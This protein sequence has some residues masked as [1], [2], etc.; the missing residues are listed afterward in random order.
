MATLLTSPIQPGTQPMNKS[1][2]EGYAVE[3]TV[4]LEIMSMGVAL[5]TAS[6]GVTNALLPLMNAGQLASSTAR[7]VSAGLTKLS[8]RPPKSCLT[9]RMATAL[10]MTIIHQGAVEGRFSPSSTPVT[11]AE[12]SPAV[13]GFLSIS[14][15]S[16]SK[17]TQLEV[18]IIRTRAAFQPNSQIPAAITGT[19]ATITSSISTVVVF[20]EKIC[21][22][23][24]TVNRF[25]CS[26]LLTSSPLRQALPA[27]P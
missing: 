18:L 25:V 1:R 4:A 2:F 26:I 19:S 5:E 10:P 23:P 14:S 6:N 7:A 9:S 11:T 8:P 12:R 3:C 20:F 17:I 16:S 13:M 27:P 15:Q 21:G 24:E 22:A